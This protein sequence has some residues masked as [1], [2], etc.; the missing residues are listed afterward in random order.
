MRSDFATFAAVTHSEA[1]S[2]ATWSFGAARHPNAY[3]LIDAVFAR[4]ERASSDLVLQPFGVWTSPN[5]IVGKWGEICM[6]SLRICYFDAPCPTRVYEDPISPSSLKS[7][8]FCRVRCRS[9]NWVAVATEFL[10]TQTSQSRNKAWSAQSLIAIYRRGR[11]VV[12][13]KSDLKL[14]PDMKTTSSVAIKY[15][16]KIKKAYGEN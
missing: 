10:P 2:R 3:E 1:R 9:I 14:L 5:I 15:V 16:A 7:R 11:S 13:S 4:L 6:P 12:G 8:C